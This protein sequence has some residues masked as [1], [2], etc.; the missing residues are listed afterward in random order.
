MKRDYFD[1]ITDLLNS[2]NEI[3]EFTAGMDFEIFARDKKTINAV[4]RSLEVM[5]EAAAKIPPGISERFAEIPW[6][7]MTGMRNK[8]IHEYF[9][10]DIEIVWEV[11][12]NEIPILKPLLERILKEENFS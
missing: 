5:G 11:C 7:R 10:V 8:L 9:G 4:I 3:N 12:T 1:Y 6:K 2:I